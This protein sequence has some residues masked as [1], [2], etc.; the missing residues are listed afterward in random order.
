[1]K[2]P[3]D[4]GY[5][6]PIQITISFSFPT[7]LDS[8]DISYYSLSNNLTAYLADVIKIVPNMYSV[9]EVYYYLFKF[10]E[11]LVHLIAYML[12]PN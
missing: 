3:N 10:E 11:W 12:F 2:N 5:A 1:M 9:F 7:P 4:T 6:L 8:T